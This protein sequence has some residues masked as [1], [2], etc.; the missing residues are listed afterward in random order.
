MI[1]LEVIPRAS[2]RWMYQ[3]L[4]RILFHLD[5]SIRRLTTRESILLLRMPFFFF[6]SLLIVSIVCWDQWSW[7]IL[8]GAS[9]HSRTGSTKSPVASRADG[10]EHRSSVDARKSSASQSES[11]SYVREYNRNSH[12]LLLLTLQGNYLTGKSVTEFLLSV[13]YQFAIIDSHPSKNAASM[14][15]SGLCRLELKV[16]SVRCRL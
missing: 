16:N 14:D 5:S 8:E 12:L 1:Q 4:Q 6:F 15:F 7:C 13:Q 11:F 10:S 2:N 3:C 9:S